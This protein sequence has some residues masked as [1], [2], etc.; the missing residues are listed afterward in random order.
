MM[1]GDPERALTVKQLG[2]NIFYDR[3][4]QLNVAG[5]VLHSNRIVMS[6]PLLYHI[7]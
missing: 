5:G 6:E 3:R 1:K 2:L 7:E 4:P